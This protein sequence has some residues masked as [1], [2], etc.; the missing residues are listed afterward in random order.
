[1]W[2]YCRENGVEWACCRPGVVL[3]VVEDNAL[4]SVWF[5]FKP[6]LQ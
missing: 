2:R 1:M 4:V 6:T 3:G 5:R